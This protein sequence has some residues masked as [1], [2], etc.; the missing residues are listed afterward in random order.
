MLKRFGMFIVV[1]PAG[2]IMKNTFL[3]FIIVFSA[4]SFGRA[5]PR[6]GNT[7]SVSGIL[8]SY[9]VYLDYISDASQG[10]NPAGAEKL[11]F[12]FEELR[13]RD[14]KAAARFLKGIHFEMTQKVELTENIRKVSSGDTKMKNWVKRYLPLWIREADEQLFRAQYPLAAK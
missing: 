2:G 5:F 6:V 3:A 1:V 14:K 4:I 7:N 11:R 10:V 12:L 9:P 13:K 8:D